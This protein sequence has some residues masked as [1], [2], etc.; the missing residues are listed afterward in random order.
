[1]V[2]ILGEGVNLLSPDVDRGQTA[3][4]IWTA[5]ATPSTSQIICAYHPAMIID[6]TVE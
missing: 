4:S 3:D 6:L 2:G 1:M 5:P